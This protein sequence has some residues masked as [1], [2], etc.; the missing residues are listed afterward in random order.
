MRQ[1]NPR[2]TRDLGSNRYDFRYGHYPHSYH[3]V[4]AHRLLTDCFAA[5]WAGL[6]TGYVASG[7]GY[8]KVV[9]VQVLSWAPDSKEIAPPG[10]PG[11]AD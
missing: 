7:A 5:V 10:S 2:K 4:T 8:R 11:V 1:R 6:P 9:E 3:M